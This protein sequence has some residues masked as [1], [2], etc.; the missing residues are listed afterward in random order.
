MIDWSLATKIIVT[1]FVLVIT[2]LSGLAGI[3]VLIERAHKRGIRGIF[4]GEA[5]AEGVPE[6]ELSDEEAA[7]IL[8]SVI[9]YMDIT[10]EKAP[11][12]T[13]EKWVLDGRNDLMKTPNREAPSWGRDKESMWKLS[14]RRELMSPKGKN[15][16]VS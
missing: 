1:G 16:L 14:G 6:E 4:E 5:P 7:A 15:A 2:I 10:K 12:P 11:L 9:E 13:P 3:M 8:S